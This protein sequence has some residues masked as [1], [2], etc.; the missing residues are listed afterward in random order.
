MRYLFTKKVS[1]FNAEHAVIHFEPGVHEVAEE[2]ENHW[3]FDA[4]GAK[5][6]DDEGNVIETEESSEEGEPSAPVSR[7]KRR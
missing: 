3:Y 4:C 7:K 5:P 2:F 6:V 1:I